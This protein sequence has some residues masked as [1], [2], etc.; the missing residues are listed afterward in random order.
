MGADLVTSSTG[1][2]FDDNASEPPKMLL[3][4]K[5]YEQQPLVSLERAI[6]PLVSLVS[7]IHRQARDVKEKA[8][9]SLS[10]DGL[11][12]EES[13]AIRLYTIDWSKKEKCLNVVL[14]SHLCSDQDDRNKKLEAFFLYLKLFI[15]GLSRMPS[16]RGTVYYSVN[17]DLSVQFANKKNIM[18]WSFLLCTTSVNTPKF[19]AFLKT[20]GPRTMFIIDS[21]SGKN[22]HEH[23]DNPIENE[24]ILLPATKYEV[25][26]HTEEADGLRKIVLKEIQSSFS[27]L[28]TI[29]V[30]TTLETV[31]ANCSTHLP[32][33][34]KYQRKQ[35]L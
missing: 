1:F 26:D 13:A 23:S 4:I 33:E 3:A 22:I 14:T 5:G 21:I 28:D 10:T 20:K 19:E 24:I 17:M 32:T 30:Q 6:E 25:V 29:T 18:C 27:L 11:S 35:S 34:I 16:M 7:D 8:K 12:V 31:P 2:R 15:T 9:C